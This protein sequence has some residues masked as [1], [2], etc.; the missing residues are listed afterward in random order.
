MADELDK[1]K[2]QEIVLPAETRIIPDNHMIVLPVSDGRLVEGLD[3]G[4][5]CVFRAGCKVPAKSRLDLMIRKG[6]NRFLSLRRASDGR[7]ISLSLP[8]GINGP[9]RVQ[10]LF[11]LANT[12]QLN[13]VCKLKRG[14]FSWQPVDIGI[15]QV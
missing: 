14:V 15:E 7:K 2:T 11:E 4:M 13:V 6:H 1:A 8:S 12:G 9:A 5:V 3:D 10:L